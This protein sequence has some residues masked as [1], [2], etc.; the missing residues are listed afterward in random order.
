ML[1]EAG[2]KATSNREVFAALARDLHDLARAGGVEL[3]AS[4]PAVWAGWSPVTRRARAG[5]PT[6]DILYHL[7]GSKNEIF[8]L[9]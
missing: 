9:S 1:V 5:G 8:K 6:E 2:V 7:R 4:A 3:A